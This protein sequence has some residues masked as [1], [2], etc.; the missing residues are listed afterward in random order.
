MK[1][2]LISLMIMALS[3]LTLIGCKK[4]GEDLVK[5]N[6]ES[7]IQFNPELVTD[8][9]MYVIEDYIY[10]TLVS[11][12][13]IIEGQMVVNITS[14]E[15]PDGAVWSTA[16][17]HSL[18]MFETYEV[19][20]EPYI[21]NFEEVHTG[22]TNV[23]QVYC[24]TKEQAVEKGLIENVIPF[25]FKDFIVDGKMNV[26]ALK[27]YSTNLE[28]YIVSD[29]MDTIVI[30]QIYNYYTDHEMLAEPCTTMP[31][32]KYGYPSSA[33]KDIPYTRFK[34]TI[35]DTSCDYSQDLYINVYPA[36]A[37]TTGVILAPAIE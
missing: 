2:K 5:E 15:C 22:D 32:E 17:L 4:D 3:A 21:I 10:P 12:Y 9:T 1:K 8:N 7:I 28:D 13:V 6:K 14:I 20:D 35:T 25:T 24:L 16:P 31:Y 37:D 11:D 36:D 18:D 27:N 19:A 23:L 29:T 33:I 26:I 34:Y 30:S